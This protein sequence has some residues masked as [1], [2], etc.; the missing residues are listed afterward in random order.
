[1][2]VSHRDDAIIFSSP[3]SPAIPQLLRFSSLL[4]L[5]VYKR[6][7]AHGIIYRDAG[8]AGLGR[9][10]LRIWRRSVSEIVRF[11]LL[12][13]SNGWRKWLRLSIVVVP[14]RDEVKKQRI[15][16]SDHGSGY[17]E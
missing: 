17:L 11:L 2:S 13:S 15:L 14:R 10:F 9:L 3:S 1:M 4:F 12:E 7:S 5:C 8:F 16:S 6:S